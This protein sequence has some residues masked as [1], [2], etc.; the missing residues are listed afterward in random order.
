MKIVV[1]GAGYAGTN[2]A[3]LLSK[4]TQAEIT[5]VNPRGDFVERIRLHQRVSG[6]SSARAPLTSM[7]REGITTRIGSVEKIGDGTVTLDDGTSLDF[8]HVVLAVGSAAEPMPGTLSIG[9]WE[10]AEQ[11][12][13]AL[14]D[15]PPQAVVTVI[16]GGPTGIE[17]AA[18]VAAAR[19]DLRVRLLGA[20]LGATLGDGA[21]RR[22]RAGLDR[23]K[24][25]VVER[26]VTAVTGGELHFGDG[27]SL[28][29]D[30]TLWAI[31]AGAPAL[32]ANSG[33]T[34]NEE[35]RVVV[36]EFLRSVDDPRIFAAGD[37]AA[38]P[39]A[40]LSCQASQPQAA[41]AAA[42]VVRAIEGRP[43]EPHVVRFVAVC[44]S[45]GRADAVAQFTHPD[46]SPRRAY[47]AGRP[48]AVLKEGIS[49]GV[50][51]AARVG[52]TL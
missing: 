26:S 39:G 34:V 10:G 52:V 14:A 46:D 20:R 22:V 37:C 45:L 3:N 24:V 27:T 9:T 11:A 28:A 13:T 2:A 47:L 15:L 50:K 41:T 21:R 6:T 48:G 38:V 23:L 4:K 32:A 35:G 5:V 1:V 7:L 42:N 12:R 17:T 36:D 29:T 33:F 16:G 43:L 51:W 30:L 19:P 31:V 44:M 8:D 40:R 18:E 49:R 25:E